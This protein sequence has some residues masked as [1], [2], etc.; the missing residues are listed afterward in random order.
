M[1]TFD[2]SAEQCHFGL[3]GGYFQHNILRKKQKKCKEGS[4]SKSEFIVHINF[5]EA[6][7]TK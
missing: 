2:T 1:L 3:L 5:S 7:S 6:L 4:V